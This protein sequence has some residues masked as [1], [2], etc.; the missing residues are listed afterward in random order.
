MISTNSLFVRVLGSGE[1]V[2][3]SGASGGESVESGRL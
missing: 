3:V 2:E 1:L